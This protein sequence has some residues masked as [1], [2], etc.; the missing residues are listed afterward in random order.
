MARWI[1]HLR[2][3]DRPR[4]RASPTARS[5]RSISRSRATPSA[6]PTRLAA[7]CCRPASVRT[8]SHGPVS[9]L[10]GYAEGAWWVQ[11][12]AAA[13]PARLFGDVRG[14]T[15]ADLCAAPGGK[16]AQLAAAG[17]HGHRG[18]PR[19][20]RLERL[21]QNLA[22]L[23][24]AAETVAA[25]AA[26]WQAGPFDAVLLDAPCSSTGTIRRHPDI[27]WLKR[28][29][30]IAAL[31]G[32]Q[33]RLLDARR[34]ADQARRHARLLHLL[35]R[36][37]GRRRDRRRPARRATRGCAAGRSRRPKSAASPN[38]LT[39]AGDL[40]TLP[41]HLPDPDPRMAGL[42][43]FY[44]ARLRTDLKDL[45]RRLARPATLRYGSRQ[46]DGNTRNEGS[47]RFDVAR[48]GRGTYQAVRVPG[49]RHAAQ[50]GR[51]RQRRIPL[52]RWP[53]RRQ[54]DRPAAD[55]AAGPAHRR[56][57]PGERNLCRPLRLRRQGRGLRRPLAVRDRR[58]RRTNGR[59]RC[60]AS[61]GC[62]ICAP[63][64]PASPAPMRARWST[65][66]SRCRARSDAD[67]LAS[68]SGGAAHHLVADPGDAG[69]RRFR[70][71]V[72]PP[73]PAQP[74]PPGALPAQHGCVDARDGVP[75][76][77]AAIAL[78]YAALCMAGQARHIK[79]RDQ[80]PVGRADAPDPARRR[81]HQPQSRRADRTAARPPA[82][83]PG[84]H[85]AQHPAA[86][87]RCSTP[88]TA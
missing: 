74:H 31:A 17:A 85:R 28:E 7:A 24:L 54:Q 12:A 86:A 59:R 76:L 71:A 36:A 69:A 55:R 79:A 80:A 78:T 23:A 19:A 25:D 18:R 2:R 42:D 38:S 63:P 46:R 43:G 1:A 88:S 5:R 51:P 47:Q 40:R 22:R 70:R 3:R 13:L 41:C 83:A 48:F 77:Q 9:Q 33:R 32:L 68:R 45:D 73:L 14:K 66:G 26:E 6:G 21:R 81:P 82:A 30:D 50:A 65:N 39:P 34:R 57:H 56:R 87:A 37:G 44:A 72:L 84:F 75:R 49:A 53:L 16:T 10:P 61:A 35:A 58:R 64:N 29:R 20:G 27:P 4:D 67:R 52:V 15:V 60:S 11:D 62:A 8:S